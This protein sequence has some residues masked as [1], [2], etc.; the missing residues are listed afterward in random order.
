MS[1]C[2]CVFICVYGYV[3]LC[4]CICVYACMC[5]LHMYMYM[6][7]WYAYMCAYFATGIYYLTCILFNIKL[8][9]PPYICMRNKWVHV[10]NDRCTYTL[11]VKS[12]NSHT[13]FRLKAWITLHSSS[14]F[15]S[16][17]NSA[18]DWA[19]QYVCRCSH[20]QSPGTTFYHL[21]SRWKQENPL[22]FSSP[23]VLSPPKVIYS[24]LLARD[25]FLKQS[26]KY[27]I[28]L[29]KKIV[30]ASSCLE[31]NTVRSVPTT[32]PLLPSLSL[33]IWLRNSSVVEHLL[34]SVSSTRKMSSEQIPPSAFPAF[35]PIHL[36]SS[37]PHLYR[38]WYF[39]L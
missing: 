19:L 11:C 26:S 31:G 1:L 4:V 36:D 24:H 27:L 5:V 29:L 35:V 9:I 30:K 14:P 37:G 33:H 6:Y 20:S 21:F 25:I 32:S 2:M 3:P 23:L 18:A 12:A 13:F 39:P 8:T 15:S 17:V 28:F 10:G 7:V 22:A 34:G 38:W 16:S